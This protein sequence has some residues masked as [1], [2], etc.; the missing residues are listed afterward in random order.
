MTIQHEKNNDVRSPWQPHNLEAE[1]GLLG[2]LM[3]SPRY[4]D[5]ISDSFSSEYFFIP[6]HQ[7]I[8]EAI[9]S[10]HER[11]MAP[12][13]VLL[14]NTFDQDAGL[15]KVGG[16]E[17]LV[18]L[19]A[20][21]ITAINAPD[22]A[23]TIRDL[24]LRRQLILEANALMQDAGAEYV[25]TTA[26]SLIERTEETL[27]NLAEKG[28]S[29]GG[30]VGMA[31][32]AAGTIRQL[33]QL[34]SGAIR[35]M[36]TGLGCLDRL[37]AGLWRKH[38][39]VLA[40]RPSMGK[41]ALALSI[42]HGVAETH[43]VLFF[44]LEMTRDELNERYFARHS[45]IS[46]GHQKREGSFR[47]E[48]WDKIS[49]AYHK[50]CRLNLSVDDTSGLTIG[51]IRSRA[52][53][54]KR[55]HGLDLVIIDH[56]GQMTLP[57][58]YIGKV[59]QIGEVTRM[60]KAMA[61]DLDVNVL[62]LQQLSRAVEQREDKRPMLADLRDSGTIEQDADSVMFVYRPEYYLE[63]ND[64]VR[65][66]R[67]TDEKYNEKLIRHSEALEAARGKADIIVS[68]FRGGQVGTVKAGFN[69]TRQFFHDLDDYS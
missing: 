18:E 13:P 35:P 28:A 22:Y 26:L 24:H 58:K 11:G 12:G 50:L 30:P 67:D 62:L 63:R 69:G 64:P 32:G 61:K 53:R 41:T 60:L 59:D 38:L 5:E 7:R 3:V 25:D 43:N 2:A 31:E 51:Q 66:A 57:D 49:A 15:E 42:A 8:Y 14:K 10:L 54:F 19:A 1:Q 27:F 48:E 52:R 55:R 6:A 20:G 4:I 9:L 56:L 37:I 34:Q 45:G 39:V 44:S 16:A 23:K 29:S 33:Q 17:Y 68:K 47:Q 65:E 36:K 46:T 21:V 40:G